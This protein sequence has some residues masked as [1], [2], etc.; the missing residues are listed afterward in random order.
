MNFRVQDVSPVALMD[1]VLQVRIN[2]DRILQRQLETTTDKR[3]SKRELN[4]RGLICLKL[5]PYK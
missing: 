2:M 3:R 5:Q 1:G 4:V